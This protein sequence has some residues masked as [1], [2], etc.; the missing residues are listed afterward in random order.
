MN[1]TLENVH[2]YKFAQI[3]NINN[4]WPFVHPNYH[5]IEEK[6][7]TKAARSFHCGEGGP[8]EYVSSIL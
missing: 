6:F 7:L 5:G 8:I 3:L 1:I 2:G 4:I